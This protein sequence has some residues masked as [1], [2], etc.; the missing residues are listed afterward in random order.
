MWP[1]PGARQP[2][3]TTVDHEPALSGRQMGATLTP[4]DRLYAWWEGIEPMPPAEDDDRPQ[5]DE[6]AARR[7]KDGGDEGGE[8]SSGAPR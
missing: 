3:V 8:A 5:A 4:R 1:P 2:A 6:E 7:P